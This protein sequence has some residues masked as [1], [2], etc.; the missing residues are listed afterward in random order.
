MYVLVT[1]KSNIITCQKRLVKK[2][3]YDLVF[4]SEL[5]I[6]W[7]QNTTKPLLDKPR[8]LY[9]GR[10]KVEKGIFS[11]IKMFDEMTNRYELS[12][13]GKTDDKF[14]NK[15]SKK[16]NFLGH[17]YNAPQLIKIYNNHNISILPLDLN[18]HKEM[19][20]LTQKAISFYGSHICFS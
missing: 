7:I 4:P 20:I 19:E 15:Y 10:L 18:N 17:G 13:V 11:L 5:D 6:N 8:L 1:L 16:I 14:K 2:K 12:I 3:R 9:V